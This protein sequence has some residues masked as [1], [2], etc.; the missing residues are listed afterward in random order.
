M[1]TLK[2]AWRKLKRR[3]MAAPEWVRLTGVAILALILFG[4]GGVIV[5]A[6]LVPIP[7]ISDFQNRQVSQSTQIFDRTGNILLYD[8][9]GEEQRTS[10]PLDQISPDVQH[11][12]IAIE[13]QTFYSNPG[14]DP[15]SIVRA[16]LADFSSGSYAQGA[17]TITQQVVKN[18]LLTDDKTITRK[19][20]EVILALRLTHAYSKNDIL[21]AYL[22]ETPYGGPIYGIE[23]AAQ[24]FFG[25]D[26]SQLDLAQSAYLAA[27]P[28]A[29]TYYSPYGNNR[30][31]LDARKNL[32]LQKM[33]QQGY[34]T[35]DEYAQATAEQVQFVRENAAGIKAPHFVFYI[36]QYL[37]QKY[38]VD[39]VENGGL[40]VI[41]TLDYDLQQHAEQIVTSTSAGR[42]ADFNDSN[43][44]VVAIDPKTGQILAMVGSEDYFNNAIDGQVN[45][46]IA[47]RQPGSSFKPFVYATAFEEGYTPD[48][49]VFDLPTQFSLACSAQDN[50]NDNP[51]C[52]SPGNYDGT[53]H[54]PISMRDAIAI[55]DNVASVKVLYLA[56]IQPSISTA[57][58][59]GISTLTLPSQDYGLSLVLGGGD[60]TLLQETAAYGGFANDGTFNPPT[61]ILQVEDSSGNV[62]EQY[63]PQPKTV[64][65]PQI[66]RLINDVL[67][68]DNARAPEFTAHGVLWFQGYDIADKT[69]TT[70]DSRD[71]WVLGYDPNIVVGEWAGNNDN[72]PMVKKIAAFI[73]AP[74]WHQ[75]MA[76]ALSKYSSSNDQFPPPAPE[77]ANLPPVL[78]GNWNTDSTKGIHD[79]LYWVQKSDP[80]AGPPTIADPEQ[81]YWDYPVQIWAAENGYISSFPPGYTPP[82]ATSTPTGSQQTSGL[83]ILSP[84]SGATVPANAPVTLQAQDVSEPVADII[85][86][87]NGV[88][89][90]QSASAPYSVSVIPTS[91]GPVQLRA[92]AQ[93]LNGTV[94]DANSTFTVQ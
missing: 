11:A 63:T 81:Y 22:N 34:I 7:S 24:Y 12:T 41:T 32:V 74:T 62:L 53:F 92:V 39:A 87:L 84:Q 54:G 68:D 73:V 42:L 64:L 91:Q 9:H 3:I 61:G 37:E 28:Q 25:V 6:A 77:T 85:Y 49:I 70:D 43:T 86:Y 1:N 50:T 52:Y 13:D 16:I 94:E 56:G 44:A 10:V 30:A 29:P 40:K 20:E 79:I 38:G 46:A 5:W 89:V 31:A 88:Q 8:V 36:Q 35:Q 90:G 66:A 21:A 19:I 17:S 45:D 93:L 23:A 60:V 69:G 58:S 55:S 75:I 15:F 59:L 82:V 67:S 26:A 80:L 72:S 33:L 47:Q 78:Q 14:I 83:Q 51:P 48:T 76:Y 18:A 57:E 2:K 71:A 65:Q 27:L 4:L